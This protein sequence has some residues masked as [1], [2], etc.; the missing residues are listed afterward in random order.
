MNVKKFKLEYNGTCSGFLFIK[1]Q[2]IIKIEAKKKT[3]SLNRFIINYL[4]SKNKNN[5][6][7]VL[8]FK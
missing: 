2:G 6:F 5:F 3:Q 1:S 4:I 7:M 8:K